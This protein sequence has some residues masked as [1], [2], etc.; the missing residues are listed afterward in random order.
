MKNNLLMMIQISFHLKH[1]MINAYAICPS[2]NVATTTTKTKYF[3]LRLSV[4]GVV[5]LSSPSTAQSIA[6]A[7]VL[8]ELTPPEIWYKTA[9]RPIL[10][11]LRVR[12]MTLVQPSIVIRVLIC[13]GWWEVVRPSKLTLSHI[14]EKAGAV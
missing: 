2:V 3:Q 12:I 11:E 1:P 7:R 14:E 6:P 4:M 9:H 5:A 8:S 13:R 10:R